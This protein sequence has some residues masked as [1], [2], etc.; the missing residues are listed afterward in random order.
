MKER[1]SNIELLR[2]IC[3]IF[4]IGGHLIMYHSVDFTIGT[5]DYYIS[6]IM[7]SFFMC[8]VNTFVIISGYFGIKFNLKKLIKLDIKVIAYSVGILIV[9][10]ILGIHQ[11]DIKKDILLFIPVATKRYWFISIY[12][13]LCIISPILNKFIDVIEQCKLK[14][15]IIVITSLFYILPTIL[16][17]INAP[18]ITGDS[19]YGII[20]FISLYIIGRYIK[21]YN[22]NNKKK[23]IYLNIYILSVGSLFLANHVL[24][25]VFGFYFNTFISYDTI[26][27]LF[28]AY[29]LFM[30][31]LNI[32][33]KSRVINA[34]SKNSLAVYIIHMQPIFSKYLFIDLLKVTSLQGFGYIISIFT[35]PIVIYLSCWCIEFIR[36][37]VFNEIE[38]KIIGIIFDKFSLK[39]IEEHISLI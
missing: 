2:I 9:M 28:A 10:V 12:F 32:N 21:Y 38:D 3:M 17:C 33:I 11:V 34:L 6:N 8:A 26:F 7:R 19:G 24:S 39:V 4:I 22:V 16:Y 31:F 36:V 27:N 13:V 18:T 23:G 14:M 15:V 35:I 5:S 1:N 37:K 25:K 20:N 30:F 29:G